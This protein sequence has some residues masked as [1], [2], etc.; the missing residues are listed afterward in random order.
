MRLRSGNRERDGSDA[1]QERKQ[2]QQSGG[3]AVHGFCESEPQV[4]LA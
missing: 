3:Q 2:Q 4:R 1:S